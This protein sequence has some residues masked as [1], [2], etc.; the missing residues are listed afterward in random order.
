MRLRLVSVAGALAL[1]LCVAGQYANTVAIAQ[2]DSA[3]KATEKNEAAG[4][5]PAYF[6][7]IGLSKDQRAKVLEIQ[8]SYQNQIDAL[9]KQIE[10]LEKKRDTDVRSPLSDEQKKKLDD[11]I[12][13]GKKKASETRS[14]GKSGS[15]EKKSETESK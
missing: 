9:R 1:S 10:Q 12:D 6:A 3:D 5:V 2:S 13:A 8:A 4:R 14:K 15:T 11:L 7:Q